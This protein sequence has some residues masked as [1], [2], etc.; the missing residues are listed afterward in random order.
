MGSG[1]RCTWF[2]DDEGLGSGIHNG[3]VN[4]NLDTSDSEFRVLNFTA[5]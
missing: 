5:K 1:S 2:L 4:A 3:G